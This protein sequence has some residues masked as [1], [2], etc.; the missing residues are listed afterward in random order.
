MSHN[1]LQKSGSSGKCER[2]EWAFADADTNGND[3]V[4]RRGQVEA[5][6][7]SAVLGRRRHE[8]ADIRDGPASVDLEIVQRGARGIGGGGRE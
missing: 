8:D 6:A 1:F 5:A 7:A 4:R 3:G 2:L